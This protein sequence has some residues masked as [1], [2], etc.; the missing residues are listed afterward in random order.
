LT[1]HEF[2]RPTLS[3]EV[4]VTSECL[5]FSQI[6]HTTRL[7]AD[8][9]SDHSKVQQFYPR[10]AYFNEWFKD[11]ALRL[12]YDSERR[13]RVSAVLERQNRSWGAS[14]KALENIARLR[15]GASAV[16]TGQQVGL[17]GG[18]SFSVFKALTAVKL[19]DQATRYGVDCVPVFWLATEDHDIA[20]VS[21]FSIPGAD[22]VLQKL[23]A[24]TQG[25]P[26]AP[27][28]TVR[29]GPEIQDVVEAAAGLLAPSE[30]SDFLREA[31]GPGETF[32]SAFAR[33]FARVFADWGVIL[34]DAADPEFHQIAK[35]IYQ[36]AIE[37]AS[38][39]DDALLARGK[40]LEAAGYHQQVKVTPS[41]TLL[42]TVRDGARVPVHRRVDGNGSSEF[43][44]EKERISQAELLNRVASS[45]QD[46]SGNALL[47]PVIQD[48]LLPTLAYTGGS[49]EVAYFAQVAVVYDAL[50]GRVTPI[51]PRFSATIVEAKPK[52]LLERYG[53]RLPDLFNG[54]EALREQM[55]ARTL[56]KELQSAFDHA[57][58]SL[59]KSLA[60]IRE[61]LA[62]LDSTLVDSVTNAAAKMQHQ[63]TQLRSK[64]A[65]AELRQT[66][67][68]TRKA[69]LLSN[70]LYPNKALQ[71]RELAGI[72]FVARY[73]PEFLRDAYE[74]IH[75]DCLDHQILTL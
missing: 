45:P 46:F 16:V 18:P 23:T 63:L 43:L 25:V 66:E 51:V 54:P 72:Y 24:P 3:G 11:E 57:E 53:L 5:P 71:E 12:A 30:V 10:S 44:L 52:T 58:T 49:A 42:F 48:Y 6:P 26:D 17:F 74:A 47:R 9:L 41:S 29:F 55:A 61:G 7:F 4:P 67:V 31:Y 21:Q 20:E 62:R 68:L 19:A 2:H 38:E 35:P 32:G 37:H 34:L 13:Q 50:L 28:G 60:E 59:E 64:A 27:V 14:A 36:K 1:E 8:F 33:L 65:R 69:D 75:P 40:A 73:G 22:G 15:A 39:L 70:L 56:P